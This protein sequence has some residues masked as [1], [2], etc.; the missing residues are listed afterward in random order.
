MKR[1]K[2][3]YL[4]VWLQ[5]WVEIVMYVENLAGAQEVISLVIIAAQNRPTKLAYPLHDE[6][7]EA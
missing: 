5:R 4:N 3:I 2:D 1:E 6:K 7:T